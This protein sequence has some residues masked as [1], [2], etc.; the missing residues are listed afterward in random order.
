MTMTASRAGK[1][2]VKMLACK[3]G[4]HMQPPVHLER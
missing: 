3:R 1:S 4:V 2:S